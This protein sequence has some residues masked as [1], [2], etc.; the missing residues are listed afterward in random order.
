MNPIQ[1]LRSCIE[2]AEAGWWSDQ[3]DGYTALTQVEA[4]V[5]AAQNVSR[6]E[7]TGV[8]PDFQPLATALVP[9]KENE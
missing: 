8:L 7:A 1:V 2:Q 5:E 6:T 4:L 9:F 3:Q